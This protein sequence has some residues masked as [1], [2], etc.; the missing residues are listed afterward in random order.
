MGRHNVVIVCLPAGRYGTIAASVC[1]T[2]LMEKFRSIKVGLMVGIGG[3]VPSDE[4]DIRLGDVVISR[5]GGLVQYDLGKIEAGGKSVLTGYLSPPPTILLNALSKFRALE[6]DL[7]DLILAHLSTASPIIRKPD[8]D[9]LNEPT[10]DHAGEATCLNCDPTRV[11]HRPNRDQV[12]RVYYGTIASGNR[13]IKDGVTRDRLSQELGGALCFEM[14]A[15][16]VVNTLPCL[17]IRGICDYCDSHKNKDWQG[18]AAMVAAACAKE[19]L[20]VLPTPETSAKGIDIAAKARFEAI[21]VS[22]QLID[23]A[24]LINSKGSRVKGTCE[25]IQSNGLYSAW[26]STHGDPLLWICGGPG[27]GKTTMAIYLIEELEAYI[28]TDG[29]HS[30]LIFYFCRHEDDKHNTATA[31][32]RGLIYQIIKKKP[33]LFY[34]VQ[35]FFEISQKTD[36]AL[37]HA[38]ELW[39]IFYSLAMNPDAGLVFCVI[40]GLDE[41]DSESVKYLGAKFSQLFAHSDHISF[42]LKFR[43]LILSREIYALKVSQKFI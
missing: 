14:E 12:F 33:S 20:N 32:L 36:Y 13:V 4:A 28:S 34:H 24:N 21:F 27:K 1:A 11:E 18:Y 37:A 22:D 40:D 26:K 6:K 23:R 8:L 31:V 2:H 7:G 35:S 15:A 25:W 16:G 29:G 9:S 19:L 39:T 5:Y 41:C 43:L 3:G 17:V 38:E 30:D 10:Y 42:P